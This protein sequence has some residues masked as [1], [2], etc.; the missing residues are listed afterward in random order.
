[1]QTIQ[2]V[3]RA[4]YRFTRRGLREHGAAGPQIW[5]LMSLAAEGP[6][7][8]GQLADS[9]YLHISTVSA[10]AETLVKKGWAARE[11]SETDRRV[12]WLSITKEGRELLAHA[13]VPP[14]AL[15]PRGLEQLGTRELLRIQRSFLRVSGIMKL[16]EEL[17]EPEA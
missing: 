5:A 17:A 11:R 12:V 7:T 15:L 16:T 6:M 13:P 3:V 8:V 9:M 14:R 10:L 1:M 4:T 2:R